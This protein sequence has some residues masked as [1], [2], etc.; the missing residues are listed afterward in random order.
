VAFTIE[1]DNEFERRMPDHG[2]AARRARGEEGRGP[3]LVSVAMWA[4]CVRHVTEAGITVH[5]V[6]RLARTH[7]NLDGVRR[8]GYVTLDGA[9]RGGGARTS[10]PGSVL[11][12]TAAGRRANDVWGQ[13]D[14]GIEERWRNRF[15]VRAVDRLHAALPPMIGERLRALPDTLPILRYGLFCEVGGGVETVDPEPVLRL[16]LSRVLLAFA[17]DYE[18]GAGL[19]LA[20][21]LDVVRVLDGDGVRVADLPRLSGVSKEAIALALGLLEK[22]K[23]VETWSRDRRRHARLTDRGLSAQRRG[24]RRVR[25]REA[26]WRERF[27]DDLRDALTPIVGDGTRGGSPLFA[28]LDPPADGWRADVPAPERLPWFP[29]VLHRGGWPDGS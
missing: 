29:M 22:Q 1:L 27:G 15:G 4:N 12:L 10:G 19:S 21:V 2:T 20:V 6:E 9:G 28:G 23:C 25:D 5:E 24:L 11:A 16:M 3:N 7:A 18:R 17:L 8:W 26:G 14:A 13:L